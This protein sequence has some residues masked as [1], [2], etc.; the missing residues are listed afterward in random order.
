LGHTGSADVPFRPVHVDDERL[1]D[2]TG[3]P[4]PVIPNNHWGMTVLCILG[5]IAFLVAIVALFV[6]QAGLLANQLLH[7]CLPSSLLKRC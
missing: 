3:T 4:N 6:T 1:K 5:G 7:N 2:G